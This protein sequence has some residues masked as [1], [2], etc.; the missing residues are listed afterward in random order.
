[1][2]NKFQLGSLIGKMPRA[3]LITAA[4]FFLSG[5]VSGP[6]LRVPLQAQHDDRLQI[7]WLHAY[8][9][10][11]GIRLIGH[12]RRPGAA[13][14]PISGH[15]HIVAQFSDGSEPLVVNTHWVGSIGR[16][17]NRLAPFSAVLRTPRPD[18]IA[19]IRVEYRA[20]WDS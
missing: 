5:C 12:V 17:G 7:T 1:M 9:D 16:R 10:K 15:L 19:D 2:I 3:A 11:Q 4:I 8:P 18:K 13:L 20:G 6:E 14:G